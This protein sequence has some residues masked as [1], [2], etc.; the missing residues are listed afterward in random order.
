MMRP[1]L[2]LL[3][4][5]AITTSAWA[6]NDLTVSPRLGTVLGNDTVTIHLNTPLVCPTCTLPTTAVVGFGDARGRNVTI[7]D[8]N[9]ITVTTP[10]HQRGVVDVV[11][12]SGSL[13]LT[14]TGQ[15]SFSGWG[16]AIARENYEAVLIPI[17]VAPGTPIPGANFSQWISELWVRNSASRT[18]E[19]FLGFPQCNQLVNT[20]TGDSPFPSIL[21]MTSVASAGGITDGTLAYVQRGGSDTFSLSL[22]VRDVS[23]TNENAGTDIPLVREEEFR[24]TPIQLLNVPIDSLSRTSLRVY[25]T[26]GKADTTANVRIYAMTGGDPLASTKL[27]LLKRGTV[28]SG[29]TTLASYV[30]ISDLHTTFPQLA[31]GRYRV[32]VIPANF[33]GWAFA[34]STNNDTQLVTTVTPQ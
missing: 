10:S 24:K 21:P 16:G 22:R 1:T 14:G 7:V 26:E 30:F 5:L 9:T 25:D 17:S 11:V 15:F 19:Y 4:L 29:F 32:E 18:V 8:R 20:C 34:S 2:V 27:T 6:A 3:A 33:L 31:D 23:R 12:T 13:T 28:S